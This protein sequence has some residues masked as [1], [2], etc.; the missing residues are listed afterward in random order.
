MPT[1]IEQV[2]QQYSLLLLTKTKRDRKEERKM[3]SILQTNESCIEEDQAKE[4]SKDEMM[5]IKK[6]NGSQSPDNKGISV[7]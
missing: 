1:V 6:P 4:T 3:T 2:T 7:F 5:F